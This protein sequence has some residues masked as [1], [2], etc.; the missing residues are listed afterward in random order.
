[1]K[2]SLRKLKNQEKTVS[3][4]KDCGLHIIKHHKGYDVRRL[5]IILVE[6]KKI[7]EKS[8]GGHNHKKI[9]LEGFP[10][11]TLPACAQG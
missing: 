6:I 1:M 7:M 5:Y 11:R 8:V 9:S 10:L 4:Y 2:K 3:I